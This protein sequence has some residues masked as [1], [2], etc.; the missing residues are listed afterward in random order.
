[1]ILNTWN[2]K[3][4]HKTQSDY[5]LVIIFKTLYITMFSDGI[6][7]KKLTKHYYSNKFMENTQ[8]SRQIYQPFYF[9]C[10]VII[11]TCKDMEKSIDTKV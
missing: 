11:T 10:H 9:K 4:L 2:F 7:I 5:N 8:E 3:W 6:N 1:M